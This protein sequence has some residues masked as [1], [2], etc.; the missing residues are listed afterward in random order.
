MLYYERIDTNEETASFLSFFFCINISDIAIITVRNVGYRRDIH[1][2][3]ES[4]A[5]NLLEK[6][7]LE[8][9]GYI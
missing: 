4:K 3:S 2:S 1:N 6:S 7:V 5:I 9:C 8:D